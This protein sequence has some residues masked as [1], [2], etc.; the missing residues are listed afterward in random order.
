M[1]LSSARSLAPSMGVLVSVS[2]IAGSPSPVGV[3]LWGW[4]GD[5]LGDLLRTEG[6]SRIQDASTQTRTVMGN[7]DSYG[8]AKHGSVW[9]DPR[10]GNK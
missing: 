3:C 9:T 1:S 6:S 5:L 7:G 2:L 8:Q 4:Q 10:E